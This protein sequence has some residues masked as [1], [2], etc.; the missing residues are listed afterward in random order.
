MFVLPLSRTS[1]VH[2]TPSFPAMLSTFRVTEIVDAIAATAGPQIDAALTFGT[3]Y[4][5]TYVQLLRLS[6]SPIEKSLSTIA[7]RYCFV[8]DLIDCGIVSQ[9]LLFVACVNELRL[10]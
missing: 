7:A 2:G 8:H 4:T 9:K 6:N 3:T 10:T 5:L 1:N